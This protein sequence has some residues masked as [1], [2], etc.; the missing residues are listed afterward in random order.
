MTSPKLV[1]ELDKRFGVHEVLRR[2][3]LEVARGT[4]HA[5]V[6]ENGAG[7]STLTKL[8]CRFYDP[9]AG[10]IEVD[11]RDL[12]DFPPAQLRERISA[13]FQV[14]AQ[15][16]ATVA[17]NI[18]PSVQASDAAIQD[19]A[20]AAGADAVAAR[21]DEGYDHPLGRWFQDG[22]ELSVGEWQRIALA[23]AFFRDAPILLLDEPTSAMD[24]W[25]EAEWLDRFRVMARGRTTILIT[26]RFTTARIADRIAVMAA[27]RIV[28]EGTHNELLSRGGRYAE[29]WQ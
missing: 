11:G 24:P 17:E 1:A 10:S 6:G 28:E 23:R 7:K 2:A 27:G 14:P 21:L 9:D 20:H 29:A 22:A 5:L 12:R 18:A 4:V 8:L 16:Q 19:A 26:H 25:A 3:R 15:Y 13:L